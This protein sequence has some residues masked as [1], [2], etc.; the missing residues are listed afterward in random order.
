MGIVPGG[1]GG[2]QKMN[3]TPPPLDSIFLVWSYRWPRVALPWRFP[4][5]TCDRCD[6]DAGRALLILHVMKHF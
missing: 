4:V 6:A 3:N 1:G 2:A 5:D